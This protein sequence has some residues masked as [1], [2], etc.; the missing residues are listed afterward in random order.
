[1]HNKC[2]W[3]DSIGLG[4]IDYIHMYMAKTTQTSSG[5][6]RY[7]E[8]V[9]TETILIFSMKAKVTH[10]NHVREYVHTYNIPGVWYGNCACVLMKGLLM[11]RCRGYKDTQCT[12]KLFLAHFRLDH[13]LYIVLHWVLAKGKSWRIPVSH[14]VVFTSELCKCTKPLHLTQTWSHT[15]YIAQHHSHTRAPPS[16]HMYVQSICNSI[17]LHGYS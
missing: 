2:H 9:A 11:G 8:Y 12:H 15:L 7:I 5:R 4:A 1:M 3:G 6:K 16:W 13:S 17:S 10:C 14:P